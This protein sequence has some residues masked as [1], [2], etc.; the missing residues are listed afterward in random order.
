ME[1]KEL[2][3]ESI[4]QIRSARVRQLEEQHML[5]TIDEEIATAVNDAVGIKAAK[6]RQTNFESAIGAIRGKS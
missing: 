5:A 1:Y 4:A 3:A 2:D 6:D